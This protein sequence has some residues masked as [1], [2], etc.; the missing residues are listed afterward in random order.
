MFLNTLIQYARC[1]ECYK[2]TTNDNELIDIEVDMRTIDVH[3][4]ISGSV[5]G[6][7]VH[8]GCRDEDGKN[9]SVLSGLTTPQ[10]ATPLR[11]QTEWRDT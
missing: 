3:A 9:S 11:R 4:L 2:L 5:G 6:D 1:R 10:W 7:E 8:E